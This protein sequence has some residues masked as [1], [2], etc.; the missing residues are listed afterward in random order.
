MTF[1]H[2]WRGNELFK[3]NF[4]FKWKNP[5]TKGSSTKSFCHNRFWLLSK[6]SL[7]PLFLTDNIKLD[8]MPT[9]IKLKIQA[10]FTL[11]FK[12]WE[13][14][15]VKRY[16]I[17]PLVLLFLVLHQ[18]LYQQISSFYNFLELHST[19]SEKDFCHKFSFFNR[20][21]QTS[22]PLN[23]QN[24]LSVTKLFWPIFPKMPSEKFFKKY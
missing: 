17:Q 20:F 13:G 7:L 11:C 22:H 21:T 14:T 5:A 16:K 18:L 23:N 9:N 4:E 3:I 6:K 10:C 1:L 24:L 19:L 8:G 15:S 2:L 12:F